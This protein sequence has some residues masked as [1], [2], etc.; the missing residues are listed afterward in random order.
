MSSSP[1]PLVRSSQKRAKPLVTSSRCPSKGSAC[2][3]S[4]TERCPGTPL[5]KT[6]GPKTVC[7]MRFHLYVC[8][9]GCSGPGRGQEG[10]K[11]EASA[12]RRGGDEI[13]AVSVSC[14]S[15]FSVSFKISKHYFYEWE[16]K[17]PSY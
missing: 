7:A 14:V 13:R 10:N 9:S 5:V 17:R 1:E 11:P 12:A 16:K 3:H 2:G 4:D 15:V 6:L 8:I